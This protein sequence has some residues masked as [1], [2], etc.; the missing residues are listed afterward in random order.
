VN[1]G[2]SAAK[3]SSSPASRSR[4]FHSAT[5]DNLKLSWNMPVNRVGMEAV[6][7]QYLF[8]GLMVYGL[9]DN[10]VSSAIF[11]KKK[12]FQNA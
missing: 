11:L 8:N 5:S 1:D 9:F 3:G 4:I 7:C 2:T 6:C 10:A 12:K